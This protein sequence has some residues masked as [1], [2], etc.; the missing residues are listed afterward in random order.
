MPEF[1]DS[2]DILTGQNLFTFFNVAPFLCTQSV[3]LNLHWISYTVIW[4]RV[5]LLGAHRFRLKAK[6]FIFHVV[7][8]SRE[9][10]QILTWTFLLCVPQ[11]LCDLDFSLFCPHSSSKSGW[12]ISIQGVYLI[13]VCVACSCY[14]LSDIIT[15]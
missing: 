10:F 15:C 14:P 2:T 12:S 8:F 5:C 7:V 13:F 3:V 11:S 9:T 1:C 4:A 6:D